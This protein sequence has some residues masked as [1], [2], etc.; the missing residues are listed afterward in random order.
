MNCTRT[1][2][3]NRVIGAGEGGQGG[4][5]VLGRAKSK[6]KGAQRGR[7]MQC[8]RGGKEQTVAAEQRGRER[9]VWTHG[10]GLGGAGPRRPR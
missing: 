4:K 3:Y 5:N 6:S 9:E 10:Q 2:K 1:S 7:Y 8:V